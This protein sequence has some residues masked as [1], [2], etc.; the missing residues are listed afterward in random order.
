MG[1]MISAKIEAQK[2]HPYAKIDTTLVGVAGYQN[3]FLH[4]IMSVMQLRLQKGKRLIF[5]NDN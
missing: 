4:G 3:L 2:T 1:D 5:G